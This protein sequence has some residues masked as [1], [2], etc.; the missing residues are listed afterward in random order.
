METRNFLKFSKMEKSQLAT[1]QAKQK[2][3]A[4]MT[5]AYNP[6]FYIG[7]GGKRIEGE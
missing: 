3:A 4:G 1:L 5:A 6:V 7:D 2:L